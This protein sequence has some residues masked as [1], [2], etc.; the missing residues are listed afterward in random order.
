KDVIGRF[1]AAIKDKS[2]EVRRSAIVASS[3]SKSLSPTALLE[4]LS[5][6]NV[7]VRIQSIN[8]LVELKSE[9]PDIVKSLLSAFKDANNQ[10]RRSAIWAIG[11]LGIKTAEVG[12]ALATALTDTNRAVQIEAARVL[13]LIGMVEPGLI[14]MLKEA[15]TTGDIPTR[16]NAVW[17]LVELRSFAP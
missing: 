3:E 14:T 4:A 7:G 11:E 12:Q 9:I 5:D 16:S 13:A 2:A 1:Q 6:G 15:A 10:V 17:A 8:A